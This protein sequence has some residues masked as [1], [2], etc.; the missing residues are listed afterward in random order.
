MLVEE[1]FDVVSTDLID[2]GYGEGGH[3]FLKSERPL[4]KHIITN[5]PYGTNGLADLFV[6]RA[7][8]HCQKTG[9]S[10]AMLLNLRS[11]CNPDRLKKF[12]KTPPSAIYA[13]DE[14]VCWPEGKP[15][16]RYSRIAQQQYYWA[17]WRPDKTERP[18]FWWLSTQSFKKAP[19]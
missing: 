12:T 15:R 13:L 5:P 3:D 10:V 14:L 19:L 18:T 11:L 4:A 9:G 8:I 17:V 6:R 2:R 7:L 16:S 1:G